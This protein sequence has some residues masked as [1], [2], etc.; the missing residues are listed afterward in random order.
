M[1]HDAPFA[2]E[3]AP[4]RYANDIHR[5]N[6]GTPTIPGY[7]AAKAG[8]DLIRE[9][10]VENIRATTFGSRNGSPKWRSRAGSSYRRRSNRPN[11]QAG[12]G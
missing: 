4:I 12:S 3:P 2:F 10:G 8:H 9:A 7:L 6:T 11:A 5:W 1:A